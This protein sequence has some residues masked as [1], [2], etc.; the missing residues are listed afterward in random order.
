MEIYN[1]PDKERKVGTLIWLS[2]IQENAE[3]QFNEIRKTI[4]E[5]HEK[6][7][8]DVKIIRKH[9]IDSGSEEYNE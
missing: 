5:Q 8:K 6:F 7:N 1:L 3:R 4:Q 9:Q 2:E